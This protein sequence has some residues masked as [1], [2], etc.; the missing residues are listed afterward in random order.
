V[1]AFL[2]RRISGQIPIQ[3][4]ILDWMWLLDAGDI[5]CMLEA[6]GLPWETA[7]PGTMQ[8]WNDNLNCSYKNIADDTIIIR[9]YDRRGLAP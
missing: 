2:D 3:G 8:K 5:F 4:H 6:S 1:F 7:E 9:I